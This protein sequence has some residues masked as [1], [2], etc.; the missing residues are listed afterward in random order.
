MAVIIST[1]ATYTFGAMTNK[2]VT[3]L[4]AANSSLSRLQSGMNT[5]SSGYSGVAGTQY[6][7]SGTTS[8]NPT[9]PTNLFGV[10][11]DANAPGSNGITYQNAMDTIEAAWQT[12]WETASD[13]LKT[14][15]NGGT[16]MG[17]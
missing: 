10:I 14:L 1:Q 3:G 17:M 6:E 7:V 5:A 4:I 13:A 9:A 11:A 15:D 12:F 8:G 2:L 16:P